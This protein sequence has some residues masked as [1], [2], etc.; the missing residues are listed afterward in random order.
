MAQAIPHERAERIGGN[1]FQTVPAGAD[2][3]ILRAILH[4]WADAESVAILKIVRAAA[5]PESR[6][7][8]ME[9]VI[10]ETPAYAPQKWM[11]LTMLTVLGGQE[12][13]LPEYRRLF[14]DAG[15]EMEQ[16]IPVPAAQ[17]TLI[18]G[19]PRK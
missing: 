4:D 19:R 18:V 12:R 7:I 3:Y 13:T 1:F 10:Q 14:E 2:A 5:K 15:I 6:V 8:V 9:R 17:A 11:D 16:T